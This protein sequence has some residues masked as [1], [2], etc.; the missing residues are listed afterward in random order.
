MCIVQ[1]MIVLQS[2]Y[3]YVPSQKNT[4]PTGLEML[5]FILQSK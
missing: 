4:S 2:L 5:R 1:N 3:M